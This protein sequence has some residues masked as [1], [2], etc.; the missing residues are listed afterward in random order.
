VII[1]DKYGIIK[2]GVPYNGDDNGDDN[3]DHIII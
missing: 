3:G 2:M 1:Y